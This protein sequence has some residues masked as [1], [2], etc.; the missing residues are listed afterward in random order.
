[1]GVLKDLIEDLIA[2]FRGLVV[3]LL[4]EVVG[5]LAG[6]LFD[7]EYLDLDQ[8]MCLIFEVY[9]IVFVFF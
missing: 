8:C 2:V 6:D 7:F 1:M 3:D 4:L 5:L 9:L